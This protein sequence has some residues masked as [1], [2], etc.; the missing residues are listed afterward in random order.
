LV[1]LIWGTA[2]ASTPWPAQKVRVQIIV[3]RD[4]Q[5]LKAALP[6]LEA[7]DCDDENS[8][9]LI[10]IVVF[11]VTLGKLGHHVSRTLLTNSS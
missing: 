7:I 6:S 1:R 11:A 2:K 4:F 8:Q 9:N 10:S 5:A 3:F